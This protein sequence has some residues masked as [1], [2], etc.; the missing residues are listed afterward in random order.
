MSAAIGGHEPHKVAEVV[1]QGRRLVQTGQLAAT[2]E[3][4]EKALRSFPGDPDLS[5]ELGMVHF[6]QHNWAKAIENYK[7]SISSRPGR[8]KPLF[9][10][11]EAYFMESNLD[12]AREAIAQAA[13]IAPNDPQVCQKYGEYLS[14]ALETRREGLAWLQ[15]ARRLSPGLARIDFEIGKAQFELTD[16]QAAVSSFETALK[17]NSSDGQAAFLLAESW[18]KLS[19]WKKARKCYSYALAHGYANGATYYGLGSALVELGESKA[20]LVPLQRAIAM[21]PSLIQAHFQLGKAYRQLGR[22]AEARHEVRLFG[23]MADRVDTSSEL[24][25]PETENAWRQVKPLLEENKEREA[26]EL[27]RKLPVSDP[28]GRVEPHYLLGVMYYSLRRMHDAKRMLI[29][30]R[31][32]APK[33]ARI[34]AYLGF[35][36]LATLETGAA[37]ESFQSAL[38]QDSTETL[39]LIGMGIIRYRQHRWVDAVHFLEKSRTADPKALY[40]LCDAYFRIKKTKQALLIAEVIRA[41]ASHN[42]ALLNAVDQLVRLQSTKLSGNLLPRGAEGGSQTARQ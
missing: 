42:K 11:A 40:M 24:K 15:K 14:M 8:V 29:I 27:L 4:Y 19:E 38:S 1:R 20:A 35:L 21:Q 36:E 25:G 26:L 30:A 7:S 31:T 32:Q 33:S 39:A 23:A 13:H 12:R 9:Y 6:R 37:E 17:N 5:F 2:Q 16:F 18:A 41:L 10:L 28:S 34:A 22:T 3:L